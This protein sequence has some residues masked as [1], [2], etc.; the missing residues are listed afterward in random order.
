[1]ALGESADSLNLLEY[2]RLHRLMSTVP[3]GF[4]E[5]DDRGSLTWASPQFCELAG[6]TQGDAF[7]AGW[8]ESID[9][10]DRAYVERAWNDAIA[11]VRATEIH[12]RFVRPGGTLYARLM[13]VP[14]PAR[15][16]LRFFAAVTNITEFVDSAARLARSGAQFREIA[17][18]MPQL[19]WIA[20]ADGTIEYFNKPWLEYTGITVADA[21][22]RNSKGIVH[23]DDFALMLERWNNAL[24]TGE[25]YEFEYRLRRKSDGSYR[26]FIARASP[27]RGDE[28]R[29][30][31]WIGTATDIDAQKR[32]IANLRF[33]ID[34]STQFLPA[35]NVDAICRS[36]ADLAI[37]RVADSCWVVLLDERGQCLETAAASRNPACKRE[38]D[39]S[40]HN[41]IGAFVDECVRTNAP[42]LV[43]HLEQ[44]AGRTGVLCALI[45]PLST[46]SG[47]V[48]GAVST[49]SS[50]SGRSFS[51]EDLEVLQMVARRAAA[52]IHTVKAFDEEHRRVQ[53]LQLIS[54]ASELIFESHDLQA[55]F[56][57]VTAFIAAEL[58]DLAYIMQIEDGSSLRTVSCAHRD[59]HKDP[60]T[61]HLRGQ[62]TL[63]PEAEERTIRMLAHHRTSVQSGMALEHLLPNIWDYLA[64]DV[65]ALK[66]HSAITVPLYS[67][68]ETLGALVAYWCDSPRDFTDADLP[69]FNDLGRR[70]SIAIEH[71]NALQRE[72]KIAE[73]LQQALLPSL[74]LL[75]EHADLGFSAEYR[76]SS[77]EAEVGGDWYDAVTLRDGTIMVS[78]GDVTGRGLEAAGLMG[79]VRQA[80]NM[81]AMYESDPARILDDID[82]QLRSRRSPAIVTA[83]VGFIDSERKAIRYANAG[84]PP[85]LL[86]RNGDLVEL[87]SG[88]LPLGLRDH[89]E[90]EKTSTQSL[91]GAQ[92]LALY[93][94]GLIEGTRDLAFGERRLRQAVCSQAALY[95]R[96]T[97][98]FIC[99]A[100]L[101]FEIQDDT[102]VLTVLFGER[103]Q[104]SFDAE[105]AQAAHDARDRFMAALR[106][107]AAPHSDFNA[108]ELIFGELIGNVVRHAPGAIDVQL[109]WPGV[110]PVLHVTD[111]GKGFV[112]DATLPSNPL[113]ESGRGLYIISK[114]ARTV[115]IERIPGYGNHIAVELALKK[116]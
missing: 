67:R 22:G 47:T 74:D 49:L 51:D 43:P 39:R 16:P 82:F 2:E 94:D 18:A 7:A 97:A 103:I 91:E 24:A 86:R 75:P 90:A 114:M 15:T 78:V 20:S 105:N 28:G 23:P 112:R 44:G 101:P 85:P 71:V 8:M 89:A 87:R 19:A 99:D 37:E 108:A 38:G 79:K 9:A 30:E 111:R 33:V 58:A 41:L 113:S 45:V 12:F 54:R 35:T 59:P 109:E 34:A 95:V 81:A 21:R 53:R 56:D 4:F 69:V 106:S 76:P 57:N 70:L 13:L 84:H 1:M 25:P 77:S 46:E 32:A 92:L 27:V 52:A 48:Y 40:Y 5:A 88:G 63:R 96:N 93:T 65:R 26:W 29:V 66:V 36:M 115:R 110:H 72:R 60:I 3:V 55:T 83:F 62:R 61:A 42:M 80:I 64:P 10:Q 104:W 102:A 50:A 68:G 6:T 98:R 107:A 11:A 73:A 14:D 116:R 31:R 17:Q 100:C